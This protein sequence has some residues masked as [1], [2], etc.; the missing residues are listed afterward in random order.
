[1]DDYQARIDDPRVR[2][3]ARLVE[4]TV[5]AAIDAAT[6]E[7]VVPARVTLRFRDGSS[8]TAAVDAPPGAPGRP[9]SAQRAAQL[10][11]AATDG[12]IP[13]P[14]IDATITAVADLGGTSTIRDVAGSFTA[15]RTK[16]IIS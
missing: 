15:V 13:A 2:R 16:G 6:T 10:F 9:L 11:H 5:D 7:E 1:V 4:C 8:A 12:L 3:L 14:S